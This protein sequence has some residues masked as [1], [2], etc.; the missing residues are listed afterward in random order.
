MRA[1]FRSRTCQAGGNAFTLIELLVV[2]AIIAILAALLLPAL[3][4]AKER[5]RRASCRSSMRQMILGIMMYGDDNDQ[6]LPTGA[7]NKSA[8][9][10]HLPVLSTVASNAIAQY[11]GTEKMASCPSFNDYFTRRHFSAAFDEQEYGFVVGYNYHGGHTNTPWPAI[12]GTNQW[13]SPQRLTEDPQLVL[14][15][16]MNDWSPG[17]GQTFAPHGKNGVIMEGLDAANPS[18]AG[19]RPDE[20]G[21]AGGNIG[22]LDGSI[23]WKPVSKMRIYRGSQQWGDSGCWAMW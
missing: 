1:Q 18:A 4:G 23:S 6:F 13:I 19:A 8:D 15:S 10:D 11:S 7:S 3:M 14:V 5:A 21:A 17:Y 2:I 12:F 16:D 20:V 9:D 22:L